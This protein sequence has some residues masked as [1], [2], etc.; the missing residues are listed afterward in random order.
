MSVGV[1]RAAIIWSRCASSVGER[2]REEQ[3][4]YDP[5]QF[6]PRA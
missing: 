6:E 4:F 1:L 5:A 2:I 3:F